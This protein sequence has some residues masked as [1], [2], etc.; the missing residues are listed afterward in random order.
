MFIVQRRAVKRTEHTQ[1]TCSEEL[2]NPVPP[3]PPMH[4]LMDGV[5]KDGGGGEGSVGI[6]TVYTYLSRKWGVRQFSSTL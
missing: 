6:K 1:Y 5:Q 3:P 2:R 4:L